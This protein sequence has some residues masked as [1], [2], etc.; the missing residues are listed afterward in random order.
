MQM[1]QIWFE[2]SM[3]SCSPGCLNVELNQL[4]EYPD[5]DETDDSDDSQSNYLQ[6]FFNI[7]H[8]KTLYFFFQFIVL[9]YRHL[10]LLTEIFEIG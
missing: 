1:S 5:A 7:S 10:E 4:H 3:C 9:F 6:F 8:L 2:T